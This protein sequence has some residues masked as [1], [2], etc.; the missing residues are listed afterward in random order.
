ML[1]CL[2]QI[3]KVFCCAGIKVGGGG[4][5]GVTWEREGRRHTQEREGGTSK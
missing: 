5:G 4:D 3:E 1:L 2:V